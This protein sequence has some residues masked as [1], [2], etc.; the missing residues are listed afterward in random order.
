M[1]IVPA[2]QRLPVSAIAVLG[3][4]AYTGA[5]VGAVAKLRLSD[6][7]NLGEHCVLHFKEKGGKDREIPVHHDFGRLAQR[8]SRRSGASRRS[9]IGK[10]RKNSSA[11]NAAFGV[12][13]RTAAAAA[14]IG[15]MVP[16]SGIFANSIEDALPVIC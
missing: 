1:K 9:P 12:C 3:V 10:A 8:I 14:D 13:C 2:G 6:Y 11:A 16:P 7:R 15:S 4:L 5:R